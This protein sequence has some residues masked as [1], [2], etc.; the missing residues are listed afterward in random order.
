M[1]VNAAPASARGGR[2]S[3]RRAPGA[4]A[5]VAPTEEA[6]GGFEA[7]GTGQQLD[8]TGTKYEGLA[9]TVD[10]APLGMLTDIME[11]YGT[12]TAEDL[13]VKTAIPVLKRLLEQFGAVL[14]SWN[15]QRRGQP[16][17]ATYEGLRQLDASFV[18]D[19]IGAWLTGTTQADAE[20]GKGSISGGSSP[21]EQAA[22]AALSR[23]LPSS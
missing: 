9:V 13:D 4:G 1:G 3:P 18:L 17:P 11:D 12:L 7:P 10:S 5:R 15:V 14:E 20:L 16:V 19:I 6:M 2:K 23:S 21:E 22:M 8:F